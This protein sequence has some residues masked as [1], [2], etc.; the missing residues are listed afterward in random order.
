MPFSDFSRDGQYS[1]RARLS[2]PY[3]E[4]SFDSRRVIA[5]FLG[6]NDLRSYRLT[7]RENNHAAEGVYRVIHLTAFDAN[8]RRI[9][10][11]LAQNP[12]EWL[13]PLVFSLPDERTRAV[14]VALGRNLSVDDGRHRHP[15]RTA[16]IPQV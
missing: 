14:A 6:R 8:V 9:D 13:G 15:I 4:L 1:K 2:A 11:F 16:L 10:R 5:G 7:S 12:G 3:D